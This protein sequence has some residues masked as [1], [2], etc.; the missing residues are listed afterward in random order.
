MKPNRK[1]FMTISVI[2]ICMFVL[3]PFLLIN[4][5]VRYGYESGYNRGK[6]EVVKSL[7]FEKSA[8]FNP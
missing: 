7:N 4:T 5:I 3:V 2:L 8:C 6:S 1:E